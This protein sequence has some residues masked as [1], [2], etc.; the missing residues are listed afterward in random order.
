MFKEGVDVNEYNDNYILL[1]VVCDGGYIFIVKE[2]INVGVDV[3]LN[4]LEIFL[5]L[6][7]YY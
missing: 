6:V 1:I 7:V 3:N 4:Y 5:L 2:L